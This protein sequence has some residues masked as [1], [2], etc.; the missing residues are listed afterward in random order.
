MKRREQIQQF[1]QAADPEFDL[2][3]SRLHIVLRKVMAKV[4]SRILASLIIVTDGI[5]DVDDIFRSQIKRSEGYLEDSRVGLGNTDLF[6]NQDGI[7]KGRQSCSIPACR[8]AN[9]YSRW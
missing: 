8:A 2:G 5:A 3:E 9:Q 1:S 4:D 6:R 7:E